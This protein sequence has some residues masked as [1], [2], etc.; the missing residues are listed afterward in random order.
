MLWLRVDNLVGPLPIKTRSEA[1]GEDHEDVVDV[2]VLVVV[3]ELETVVAMKLTWQGTS[4]GKLGARF[5]GS[6]TP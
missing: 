6:T 4:V 5:L 2:L 3:V 1:N